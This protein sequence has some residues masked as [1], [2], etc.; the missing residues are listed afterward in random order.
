MDKGLS[1]TQL[2]IRN[3]LECP[4]RFELLYLAPFTWPEPPYPLETE[5]AFERGRGFHRLLERRFLELDPKPAAIED[6]LVRSWWQTFE[7]SGPPIPSGR[8]FPEVS[9]SVPSGIHQLLGR[10]DLLVISTDETGDLS[11]AIFDWKTSKPREI[12][13]LRNAWQTR[14]YLALLA[15]GG[16]TLVPGRTEKLDPDRLS[17]TYW[18]VGD[19][20]RPRTV[21]YSR[22]AHDQNWR[23]IQQIVADIESARQTDHWPLTDDWSSCRDCAFRAY[24]GR[25]IA[26]A[27]LS[28][29]G[30]VDDLESEDELFPL[31]PNWR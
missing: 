28:D 11:A 24:C 22:A 10:F 5:L 6:P 23:E 12:P 13:W 2:H 30:D 4:R 19:L 8:L 25:Q 20:D 26:G 31:E 3:F 15:E 27:G 16:H 14:L 9:L 1:L 21:P 18:Y 17:M 7:S 29:V